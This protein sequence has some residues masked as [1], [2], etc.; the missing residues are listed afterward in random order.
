[1]LNPSIM[2]RNM[3]RHFINVTVIQFNIVFVGGI[4][5]ILQSKIKYIYSLLIHNKN[6][7]VELNKLWTVRKRWNK[8]AR[9]NNAGCHV[10]EGSYIRGFIQKIMSFQSNIKVR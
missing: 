8:V 9:A 4:I 2:P 10:S 1:M 7:Q 5:N 6:K 3:Q